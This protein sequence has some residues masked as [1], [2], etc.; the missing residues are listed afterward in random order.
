MHLVWLFKIGGHL[1]KQMIYRNSH[2]YCKTKFLVDCIFD[3]KS[4]CNRGCIS[5]GNSCKI[6]IALVHTCLF[7]LIRVVFSQKL[8]KSFTVLRVHLVIRRCH[9]KI[10]TFAEGICH[11]FPRHDAIFLRRNRFGKN[12]AVP[13]L[14]I[15][16][17]NRRN[18]TQIFFCAIFQLFYCC[19][20]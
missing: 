2:I 4:C 11:R 16:S 17:D 18:R 3:F 8:H 6:H 14:L 13:G 1:C 5:M 12:H 19:P 20:A 10:W 15:T 9:N 7:N